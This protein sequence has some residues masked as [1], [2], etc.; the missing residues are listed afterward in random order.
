MPDSGEWICNDVQDVNAKLHERDVVVLDESE[1]FKGAKARGEET[2]PFLLRSDAVAVIHEGAT[3][4]Q[5]AFSGHE[6]VEQPSR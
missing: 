3:F 4:R 6:P 2:G 5:S 1:P